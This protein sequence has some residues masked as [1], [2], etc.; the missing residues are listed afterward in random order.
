MK[1]IKA[2]FLLSVLFLAAA[3]SEDTEMNTYPARN[4]EAFFAKSAYSY[5]VRGDLEDAYTIPVQR[6]NANGDASVPV[7][8]TAANPDQEFAFSAPATV[9]FVDGSLTSTV[10]VSFDRSQF[11]VGEEN[12][13]TVSFPEPT[14]LPYAATCKLTVVRDYT[15]V[16]WGQGTY[17]SGVLSSIFGQLITWTQIIERAE[18]AQ[19]LYRLPNFYHNAGTR[20]SEAGYHL[21]FNWDGGAAVSF[22]Y[23]ADEYGC[24]DVETGWIYP[25]YTMVLL[26]IDPAPEYSGYDANTK[27]FAFNCLGWMTAGT[28]SNWTYDTFTLE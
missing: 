12:V 10:K 20:Y 5:A 15:W 6:A 18:E 3:C 7:I 1:N 4:D 21:T 24:V 8:L 23:P 19:T 16:K 27:Q 11:T 17:E 13:V 26:Y 9:D 14:Q 25:N 28:V 22:N 2:L